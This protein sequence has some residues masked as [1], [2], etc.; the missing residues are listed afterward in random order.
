MSSADS[1]ADRRWDHVREI[2]AAIDRLEACD[3]RDGLDDDGRLALA[4]LRIEAERASARA[5]LADDV[6]DS[7]E[8]ARRVDGE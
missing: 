2:A 4:R 8:S 1:V 7:I 5:M 6:A 3:R